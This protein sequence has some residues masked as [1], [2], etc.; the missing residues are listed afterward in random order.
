MPTPTWPKYFMRTAGAPFR[1]ALTVWYQKASCYV[2]PKAPTVYALS[3]H[4]GSD[5]LE[6]VAKTI[7]R[8]EYNYVS[9]ESALSEYGIIPQIP[10]DRLTVMTTGR[11][12]EYKTPFGVIEFTHTA[13]AVTNIL[14]SIQAVGRPLRMASKVAACRDLR[15]VGRNTHLIQKEEISEKYQG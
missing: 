5:T 2:W 8:G 1:L 12:G 4:I 13:R 6:Q 15:R 14:D 9:L 10:V 11:K 3:R 7:R